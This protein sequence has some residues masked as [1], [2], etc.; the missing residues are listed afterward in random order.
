MNVKILNKKTQGLLTAGNEF[1]NVS[2]MEDGHVS[3]GRRKAT[4]YIAII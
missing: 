3:E 4:G 2:M 1:V